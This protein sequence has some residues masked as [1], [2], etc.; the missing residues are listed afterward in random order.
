MKVS[1]STVVLQLPQSQSLKDKRR[2][3]SSLTSKVRNRFNASISEVDNNEKWQIATLGIACVS[4]NSK[5]SDEMITSV[6]N[7]IES[8]RQDIDILSEERD[9]MSI[10]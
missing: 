5:H 8:S 6:L 1:I 7:F 3:L 4:N 2:V 9:I 10:S